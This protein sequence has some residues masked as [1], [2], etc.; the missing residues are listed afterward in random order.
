M[1][2]LLVRSLPKLHPAQLVIYTDRS[3]YRI[4]RAGRRFGKTRLGVVECIEVALRGGRAWWVAPTWRLGKPGWRALRR[5]ARQ[6]P[7]A[8]VNR[9][10]RLIVLPGGGEV[11]VQTARDPDQLRGDGLDLVV[12]DE[13]AYM[14]KEAWT[15]ALRSSLVDHLGRA[16]FISTPAGMT[17]WLAELADSHADHAD[18]GLHHYSSYDNP[19]LDTD[20]LDALEI[21]LGSL[22]YQQE[23]MGELVQLE[24]TLI[25]AAWF[26]YYQVV[27]VHSDGA[28]RMVYK[29]PNGDVV[30][31]EDCSRY[32]TVDP[33]LSTKETADYTAMV[34]W[35]VTPGGTWLVEEVVRERLE[36]PDVVKRAGALMAKWGGSWIGFESVAYQA[37]LVQFAKRDGLPAE[38]IPAD[39]DKVTRTHPLSARLQAGDVLFRAEAAWLDDLERELLLFPNGTHDDQVDALAYGVL[40]RQAQRKKW[41]AH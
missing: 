34:A 37:S 6:I 22:L 5:L 39:R 9:S 13:A 14:A 12:L 10:E 16:L 41:A 32:V 25:R 23:V 28:E 29:L 38:G 2:R 27:T 36:A 4:V 24:G 15:E 33:A 8:N 18:W 31:Y 19:H 35:A 30:A 40:A 11:Q 20:E 3:R 26:D 21:E 17:N 7:G 1:G